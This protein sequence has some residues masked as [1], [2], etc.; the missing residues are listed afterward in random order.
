[1]SQR[2]KNVI[3]K[4][5]NWQEIIQKAKE[6]ERKKKMTWMER[7]RAQIK[8]AKIKQEYLH[9]CP[10]ERKKQI[11]RHKEILK[12]SDPKNKFKNNF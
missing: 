3:E 4:R 8:L 11:E 9:K 10:E 2:K 1:M 7:R 5:N 6:K 12:R